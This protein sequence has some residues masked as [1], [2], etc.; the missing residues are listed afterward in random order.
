[1]L[2]N[3]TSA[4]ETVLIPRNVLHSLMTVLSR[5]PQDEKLAMI[6][7]RFAKIFYEHEITFWQSDQL[8]IFVRLNKNSH[9]DLKASLR[10]AK[11]GEQKRLDRLIDISASKGEPILSKKELYHGLY[12]S[13]TMILT[14]SKKV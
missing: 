7:Y 13:L 1:M 4:I 10:Q 5:I 8:E 12:E 14:L 6:N 9:C 3:N 2:G 11:K